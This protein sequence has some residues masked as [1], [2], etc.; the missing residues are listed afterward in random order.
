MS[1]SNKTIIDY[2]PLFLDYCKREKGLSPNSIIDYS[3]YLNQFILWIKKYNLFDLTPEKL[4]LKHI[5]KYKECLSTCSPPKS[6]TTQNT[7]LIA[8]RSLLS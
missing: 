2:I 3:K 6:T 8:L 1:K 5:E 4:S 7:Y